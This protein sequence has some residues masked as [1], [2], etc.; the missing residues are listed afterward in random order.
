MPT[1][2][3]RALLREVCPRAQAGAQPDDAPEH[4]ITPVHHGLASE[5]ALHGFDRIG[6]PTGADA[7]LHHSGIP[8]L[9]STGFEDED[10]NEAPSEARSTDLA[11]SSDAVRRASAGVRNNTAVA[12]LLRTRDPRR[13]GAVGADK[14]LRRKS[15]GTG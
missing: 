11:N 7:L 2:F 9:R 14:D 1:L 10:E 4:N 6:D 12:D 15:R 13:P 8:S 3:R 5:A